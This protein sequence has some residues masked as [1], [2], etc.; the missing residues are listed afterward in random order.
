M[1]YTVEFW[2]AGT[3]CRSRRFGSEDTAEQRA[4]KIRQAG[5]ERVD[6]VGVDG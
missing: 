5:A 6:V 3:N 1:K 2:L 4:V